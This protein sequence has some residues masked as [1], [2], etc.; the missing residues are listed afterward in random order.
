MDQNCKSRLAILVRSVCVLGLGIWF[1]S[2]AD[3]NAGVIVATEAAVGEMAPPATP[4]SPVPAA[5]VLRDLEQASLLLS[6]TNGS[7][8]AGS[9]STSMGS[10]TGLVALVSEGQATAKTS[11]VSISF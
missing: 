1:M 6:S 7:S 4:V 11:L 3:A 10:T 8:G 9:Q 2:T 5:P